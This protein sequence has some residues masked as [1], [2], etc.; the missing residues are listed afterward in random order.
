MRRLIAAG[1]ATA[2]TVAFAF[3]ARAVL[4]DPVPD[5]PQTTVRDFFAAPGHRQTPLL[6]L[7]G[8]PRLVWGP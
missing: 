2:L 7:T 3:T 8:D 5:T 6:P 4:A 1:V